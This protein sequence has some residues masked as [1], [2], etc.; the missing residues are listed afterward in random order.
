M[1][2]YTKDKSALSMRQKLEIMRSELDNERS[3]FISHWRDI[4]E[5]MLPR[6]PMFTLT[7]TNKG[8]RKNQKIVDPTASLS[9]R[10]LSS[11]MMSGVTSPARPW[12]RLSTPDP[13]VSENGEVKQWLH[14]VTQRMTTMF[15]RS[16]VYNAL[17]TIYK[18]LG[19][20]G[21]SAL[22]IEED[23]DD[24]NPAQMARGEM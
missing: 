9:I 12:F 16:N 17:P 21:T 20:F 14:T 22:Y 6:R 13:A 7:D 18:D 10:T 2:I 8:N 19:S 23:F 5:F 1:P 11:G 15:L 24:A 4:A 3:S